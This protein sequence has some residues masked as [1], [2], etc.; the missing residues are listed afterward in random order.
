MTKRKLVIITLIWV[1]IAGIFVIS[2]QYFYEPIKAK[3]AAKKFEEMKK[4]QIDLTSSPARYSDVVKFGI[5]SFSGYSTFRSLTF[6]EEAAKQSI[7]VEFV[8]DNANY[9]E[10]LVNLANGNLDMAV[11]TIDG[12]IKTTAEFNDFPATIIA[13]ID[14][15][16]G[17]DAMVGVG[18]KFPNIDSINDPDVKI[19]CVADSPSET[20]SRIV[21][22]NF[23]LERL[24]KNP[25]EFVSSPNELYKKY[26]TA[27]PSD[28][29]IFVT[30]EPYISK[31]KEN[32][33]YNILMDSSKFHGYILDVIVSRRDFVIKNPQLVEKFLKSYFSANFQNKQN[34]SQ[35]LLEDSKNSGDVL[36]KEQAEGLYKTIWFKNTQENFGHFGIVQGTGLQHI[37]DIIRNIIKVLK[38][39]GA[40][41]SDPTNGKPNSFYYTQILDSIHKSNW[42]PGFGTENI[43]RSS[44]SANLSDEEWKMLKPVG[45]LYTPKL[46]FVRGTDRLTQAS[47]TVLNE[48][49]ENLKV[50]PQCYLMVTG[51]ASSVG[52]TEANLKLAKNR[53]ENAVQWL[54]Q[55]GIDPKRI[56]VQEPLLTDSTTVEFV[57]Y[58]LPY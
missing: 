19:V 7:R 12:L 22:S 26:Q 46:V 14:E 3:E 34:M 10:R 33:D 45:T 29:K 39:T 55:H 16:R 30:W 47:E 13:V 58:E 20:L 4:R 36:K 21:M 42:H 32:P 24:G 23:K 15:S 40:I 49:S 52:N 1:F 37:D 38:N 9:K 48:L 44:E 43:L 31:I 8:D 28:K 18:S 51:N 56:K 6:S 53:S 17:A 50:F 5:D 11:F 54:T 25:F 2:Y 35:I 27:K 41:S 57:F